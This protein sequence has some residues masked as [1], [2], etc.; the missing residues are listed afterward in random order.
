M[1]PRPRVPLSPRPRV[2]SPS[3]RVVWDNPILWREIRTWAYGRKILIVRLTFLALFALAAGNLWRIANSHDGVSSRPRSVGLA[4]H[5]AV[6]PRAGERP[7]RDRPD[8]GT[9]HEGPRSAAGFRPHAQGVRLRQAGR[10]LLQH[11][12]DR[13]AA[14]AAVRLSRLARSDRAW[15]T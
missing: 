15:R 6:E 14:D 13:A 9:R 7:G 11:Q 10:D 1:S 8:C 4:A 2:L 3:H 5:A 12:G